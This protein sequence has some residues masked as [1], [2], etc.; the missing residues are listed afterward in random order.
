MQQR[1]R[2]E[3][4]GLDARILLVEQRLVEREQRLHD[5]VTRVKQDVQHKLEPRRW[6]PMA[7]GG[8]GLLVLWSLL[9]RRQSEPAPPQDRREE[10]RP[11]SALP[12]GQLFALVWPLAPASWRLAINPAMLATAASVMSALTS[13]ILRRR[14]ARM[15]RHQSRAPQP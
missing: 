3:S 9:R 7:A 8:A 11:S 12:L 2:S 1:S 6:L 14:S 5:G 15:P 4:S 13:G 10:A